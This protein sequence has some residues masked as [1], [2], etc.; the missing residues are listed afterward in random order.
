[1]SFKQKIIYAV[2]SNYIL[3]LGSEIIPK[4]VY[5]LSSVSFNILVTKGSLYMH[6]F[7]TMGVIFVI[8]LAYKRE[9]YAY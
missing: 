3:Y 2:S 1:M 7:I 9:C 6:I 5:N 4:F 8:N